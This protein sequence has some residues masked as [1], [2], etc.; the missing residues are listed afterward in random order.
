MPHCCSG[1]VRGCQPVLWILSRVLL[2]VRADPALKQHLLE[3]LGCTAVM[4]AGLS[5]ADQAL[6]WVMLHQQ[7]PANE[8]EAIE[9]FFKLRAALQVGRRLLSAAVLWC[10]SRKPCWWVV[11]LFTG[12]QGG[13]HVITGDIQE[14]RFHIARISHAIALCADICLPSSAG[15][16]PTWCCCWSCAS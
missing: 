7:A 4:P 12:G 15:R 13:I 5:A 10:V 16:R 11:C 3:A 6:L 2:V 1:G 8:R 14:D 9:H